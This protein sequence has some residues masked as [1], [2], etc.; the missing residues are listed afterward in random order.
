MKTATNPKRTTEYFSEHG[1]DR[2]LYENLFKDKREGIYVEAGALDGLFHSNT[3]FFEREMGWTGLLIE[4]NPAFLGNLY[5]HRP[6]N[7]LVSCALGSE[8]GVQPFRI[9]T[10]API[11]WSGLHS[12][13]SGRRLEDIRARAPDAFAATATICVQTRT[14]IGVLRES[15]VGEVDFLSLDVEGAEYDVLMDYPFEEIPIDVIMVEDN[16]Q[17][18]LRTANLLKANGYEHVIRLGNDEVWKRK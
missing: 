10:N 4:A 13:F 15:F 9:F 18:D 5:S 6:D 1:Q 17:D 12:T 11:G 2:W 16:Y 7:V 14:L 8:L 3:L